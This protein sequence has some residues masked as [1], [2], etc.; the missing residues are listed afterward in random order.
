MQVLS[1]PP[2]SELSGDR[3]KVGLYPGVWKVLVQVLP[4]GGVW[5]VALLS[6]EPYLGSPALN[7]KDTNGLV[8]WEWALPPGQS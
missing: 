3:A 1:P 7:S 8:V 5:E 4:G 6:H 2:A